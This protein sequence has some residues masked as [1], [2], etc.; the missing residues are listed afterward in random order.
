M[1]IELNAIHQRKLIEDLH[2]A[3]SPSVGFY[4]LVVLS[5]VIAAYGLLA[6]STAVVIGAM[7]IAPLMGPIFGITVALIRSERLFLLKA[8]VAEVIGVAL[9]VAIA[10]IIGRIPLHPDFGSEILSRTQP[11]LFDL[12]IAFFSG[13]AGAYSLINP[14]LSP[15]I[16]GVAIATA[17]VPPLATCGLCLAIGSTKLGLGAFLLFLIN[18]LAIQFAAAIVFML[19]NIEERDGNGKRGRLASFLLKFGP[20]FAVLVVLGVFLT[21]V[22]VGIITQRQVETQLSQHLSTLL[23]ESQGAQLASSKLRRTDEHWEFTAEVVTPQAFTP[24]VVANFEDSLE[25]QVRRPVHLILRSLISKDVDRNGPV[26]VSVDE[27]SGLSAKQAEAELLQQASSSISREMQDLP[28]ALLTELRRDDS[29]RGLAFTAIVQAPSAIPPL[30]VAELQDQLQ[31]QLGQP[32][33]LIVRTV[34]IRDADSERYIYTEEAAVRQPSEADSALQ[35]ELEGS[36]KLHLAKLVS[37]CSLQELSFERAADR[38]LVNA[39]VQAPRAVTPG[40]VAQLQLNVRE[41][42]ADNIELA[43]HTVVQATATAGGYLS[44]QAA[45]AGREVR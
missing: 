17:L 36:L 19:A 21:N 8:L 28:G 34:L 11:T 26:F 39:A 9:A 16:A 3:S 29:I 31:R 10:F 15:T 14:K 42:V 37:G 45:P 5:T 30:I 13:L 44:E 23:S 35:L 38:M 22:L 27:L 40:E 2:D 18:F 7:L 1:L 41:D 24:A 12:L 6:N 32:V 4:S 20:G 33:R 43:V 25:Q